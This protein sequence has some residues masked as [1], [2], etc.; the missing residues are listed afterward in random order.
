MSDQASTFQLTGD[1]IG[2]F[3][4]GVIASYCIL[5]FIF[6]RF[7]LFRNTKAHHFRDLEFVA[8]RGS[9]NEG[10]PENTLAAFAEG[11]AA[12]ADCIELDVW[13]TKDGV[14]HV[15]H[16]ENFGKLLIML[17]SVPCVFSEKA[18]NFILFIYLFIYLFIIIIIN[19]IIIMIII[20]YC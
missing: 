1:N 14:V 8:H 3:V 11:I 18:K 19:N 10:F 20:F 13:C 12:G 16:D 15:F 6:L 2:S 7:P 17:L 5:S 4:L 9:K